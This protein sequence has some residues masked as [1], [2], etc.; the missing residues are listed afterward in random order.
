MSIPK[1][2]AEVVTA[3]TP[4]LV[5]IAN[6]ALKAACN[7]DARNARRLLGEVARRQ[8]VRLAADEALRLKAKKEEG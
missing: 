6:A 4:A 8:A 1:I 3:L 5:K 2:P 7:G